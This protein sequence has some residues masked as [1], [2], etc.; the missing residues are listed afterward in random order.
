MLP[1]E[2]LLANDQAKPKPLPPD[3]VKI[4]LPLG[5]TVSAPS[6]IKTRPETATLL[7]ALLPSES[8][9][10]STSV[11]EPVAPALYVPVA[12]STVAPEELVASDHVYPVP[13]PPS[14]AK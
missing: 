11:T 10:C 2:A 13:L 3:A 14:A 6:E 5:G 1:P 8:V 4:A 7:V 12:G 9:T